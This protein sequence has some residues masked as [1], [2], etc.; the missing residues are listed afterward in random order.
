MLH[1]G[2]IFV[3]DGYLLPNSSGNLTMYF[4]GITRHTRP[5]WMYF[6]FYF[7]IVNGIWIVVPTI[8]ITYAAN[9][10][11]AAVSG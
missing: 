11:S 10:I 3:K 7:V 5:E 2:Q 1:K 8:C 4:A 6:W 9:R